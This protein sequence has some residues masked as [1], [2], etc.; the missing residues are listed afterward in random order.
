MTNKHDKIVRNEEIKA[1]HNSLIGT[2]TCI[3]YTHMYIIPSI[4]LHVL[5]AHPAV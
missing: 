4:S 3:I 1:E 5:I 2:V